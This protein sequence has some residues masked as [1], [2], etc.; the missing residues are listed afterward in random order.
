MFIC[1]DW[2][3]DEDGDGKTERLL[4]AAGE[5]LV[6]DFNH[7]FSCWWHGKIFDSH[8]WLSIWHRPR[9]SNFTRAQRL[10]VF[11]TA[12]FLTMIANAMWYR[13]DA[14]N[15]ASVWKITIGPFVIT[16]SQI[17]AS[18]MSCVFVFPVIFTL[19]HIFV[20]T[21]PTTKTFHE[22][23]IDLNNYKRRNM[24][25]MSTQVESGIGLH[26]SNCNEEDNSNPGQQYVWMKTKTH[27]LPY[28]CIYFG[29][30]L[31]GMSC[32]LGGFFTVMYSFYWGGDKANQWLTAFCLSV[33]EDVFVL[34]IGQV[35]HYIGIRNVASG[36]SSVKHC[37][38]EVPLRLD[39]NCVS[40]LQV[41]LFSAVFAFLAMNPD[42]TDDETENLKWRKPTR[43]GD[44]FQDAILHELMHDLMSIQD[45]LDHDMRRNEECMEATTASVSSKKDSH[46]D[47][48]KYTL[49]SLTGETQVSDSDKVLKEKDKMFQFISG[50]LLRLVYA[51]ALIVVSHGYITENTSYLYHNAI[52][53]IFTPEKDA[54][55]TDVSW[56]SIYVTPFEQ[57]KPTYH[58]IPPFFTLK[59]LSRQVDPRLFGT[60]PK[61]LSSPDCM[62]TNGTMASLPHG[63][64]DD[65]SLT[66][67]LFESDHLAC[68]SFESSQVRSIVS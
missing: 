26:V 55:F 30:V 43:N 40:I 57:S 35:M 21:D 62:L 25:N 41:F 48:S 20:Y 18:F 27:K 14:G 65:T 8:V 44:Q 56:F 63:G 9:R 6:K 49:P 1:D 4:S 45:L 22:A 31:C 50:F 15:D 16:Y 28:V 24:V 29:W 19:K 7:L 11:T 36:A 46:Y 66:D 38:A 64:N 23:L 61:T 32:V 51:I 58:I 10:T 5:D 42:E 47:G 37:I 60:G 2:L 33:T 39:L 54:Y 52:K 12:L 13:Q 59:C 53:T 68:D 3:S 17:Y 67:N 34:S